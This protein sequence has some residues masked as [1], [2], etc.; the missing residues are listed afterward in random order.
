MH[1]AS[2]QAMSTNLRKRFDDSSEIPCSDRSSAMLRGQRPWSGLTRIDMERHYA[3]SIDRY[4]LRGLADSSGSHPG[5][6]F[7]DHKLP[8]PPSCALPLS[9]G[10][11]VGFA[12][13]RSTTP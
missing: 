13:H 4:F 3:E 8:P 6:C 2:N 12:P 7:F 5:Y 11:P 10:N 9:P 1:L